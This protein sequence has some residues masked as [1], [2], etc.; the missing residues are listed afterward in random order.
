[1]AAILDFW[2]KQFQC[3]FIYKLLWYAPILPNKFWVNWPFRSGE[4]VQIYFQDGSG[5]GHPGFWIRTFL[6]IF[7]LQVTPILPTKFLVNWLFCSGE[8]VQNI[9]SRWWLWC[10]PGFPIGMALAI[11]A[12][13]S[14]FCSTSQS[15]IS[16]QVFS[17]LAFWFS[18]I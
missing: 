10:H 17:Q 1:M 7:Y 6:A 14:Y 16:C 4:E 5:G 12:G 8:E 9:F 18:R 13:F 11:F 3:V 2:S 15:D